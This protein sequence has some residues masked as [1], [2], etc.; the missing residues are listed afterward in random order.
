M[1]RFYDGLLRLFTDLQLTQ[2]RPGG[3]LGIDSD[4]NTKLALYYPKRQGR[5]RRNIL[6]HGEKS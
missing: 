5:H 3:P 4:P 2:E 6:A 1:T